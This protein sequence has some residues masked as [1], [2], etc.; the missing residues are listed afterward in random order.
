[1]KKKKQKQK[2]NQTGSTHSWCT[3]NLGS[4][5]VPAV[6]LWVKNLTAVTRVAVEVQDQ[7]LAWWSGLKDLLLPQLWLGRDW[8]LDPIPGPGASIFKTNKHKHKPVQSPF[9]PG[10]V[11]C[12]TAGAWRWWG[13]GSHS[14]WSVAEGFLPRSSRLRCPQSG[15]RWD[16]PWLPGVLICNCWSRK[17][18]ETLAVSFCVETTGQIIMARGRPPQHPLERVLCLSTLKNQDTFQKL[19]L[20][21]AWSPRSL[22]LKRS[23]KQITPRVLCLLL[24][25]ELPF[26]K[27]SHQEAF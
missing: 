26:V 8:G 12:S 18:S 1:M 13:P 9:L 24:K 2:T 19:L 5:G 4:K 21:S 10:R 17:A 22:I 6:A 27:S 16:A 25:Y 15:L 23:C 7:S 11:G 20:N 14:L 3:N